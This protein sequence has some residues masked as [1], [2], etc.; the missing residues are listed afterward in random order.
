MCV[1]TV[2][3]S[4]GNCCDHVQGFCSVENQNVRGAEISEK[5][6]TET[7]SDDNKTSLKF[8][9]NSIYDPDVF[10]R[11]IF[12]FIKGL[13]RGNKYKLYLITL[14]LSFIHHKMA[15]L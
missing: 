2:Y 13:T 8:S 1:L 3:G 6:V 5:H 9:N 4:G 14:L 7:R 10:Y 15:A 11:L 12:S